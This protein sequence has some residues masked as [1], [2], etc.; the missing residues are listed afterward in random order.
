[1]RVARVLKA[2]ADLVL[3]RRP[4]VRRIAIGLDRGMAMEIDF[5]HQA[6]LYAGIFEIELARH[7]R[8]LCR[9][10]TKCFDV[11]AREGYYTLALAKL[12]R[13][14][15]VLALEFDPEWCEHLHRNLDA[16]PSLVPRPEV[17]TVK[18]VERTDEARSD[19]S[20]DDVAY[21]EGGFVPDLIKM[22]IE[23][24]ELRALRGA[25]RILGERMPHLIV[26]THSLELESRCGK[27]LAEHG[28]RPL[29]VK[30]R[31]WLPE[32]RTESNRWLV[33]EGR[34]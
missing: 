11:G 3:P 4:A 6:R 14:G 15:R 34:L 30:P 2:V 13:G 18:V 12:S 26:E 5:S 8:A 1:L 22:D 27:L 16:N 25:E 24:G 9:P 20:L 10:G 29:V 21:G 33:A 23:G 7:V 19:V 28:Y 31:R 32:V 17:R